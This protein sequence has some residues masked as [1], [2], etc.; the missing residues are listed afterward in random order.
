MLS[1]GDSQPTDQLAETPEPGPPLLFDSSPGIVL[2]IASAP[3]RSMRTG[4]AVYGSGIDDDLVVS[5]IGTRPLQYAAVE[6][7]SAEE[8]TVFMMVPLARCTASE[9]PQARTS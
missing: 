7:R 2:S 1:V 6:A 8:R 4:A 9:R 5:A 3:P